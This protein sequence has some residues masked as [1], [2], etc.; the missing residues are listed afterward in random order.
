MYDI[1]PNKVKTAANFR[2][3]GVCLK[4]KQQEK[5]GNNEKVLRTLIRK[6][7]FCLALLR[8]G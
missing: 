7:D 3:W 6:D 8:R 4:Y 2:L 1:Q 5:R